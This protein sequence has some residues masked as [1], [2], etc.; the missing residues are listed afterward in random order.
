VRANSPSPTAPAS[1]GPSSSPA[2]FTVERVGTSTADTAS[3][4]IAPSGKAELRI[5]PAFAAKLGSLFVAVNPDRPR[6]NTQAPSAS[7]SA[8]APRRGPGTP[9]S[10]LKTNGALEFIQVGG[11]QVFA[12]ELDLTDSV[13]NGEWQLVLA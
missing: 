8:A 4:A 3:V 2:A 11:G 12:R 5:D 6:R 9:A 10:G 13:A 1:K 7:R